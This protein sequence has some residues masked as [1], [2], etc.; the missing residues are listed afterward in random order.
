M[1]GVREEKKQQTRQ[2]IIRAAVQLFGDQGYERTSIEQLAR[3]AGIGK[4]TIYSYF[5]TKSEIFLAYGEDELEFL[6]TRLAE[7]SDPNTPLTEQLLTLFTGMFRYVMK[8]KEFGRILMRERV[9]PEE[10]TLDKSQYLDNRHLEM[11]DQIFR[12]A[13]ERGELRPD[14][15]SFFTGAHLYGIYLITM[16]AWFEGRIESETEVREYLQ[17]MIKQALHGVAPAGKEVQ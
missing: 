6:Y 16:A 9:F 13:K 17:I 15:D 14:A 2:A 1:A 8:N 11:L 4:G 7:E 3:A 5:K 12:R 10:L